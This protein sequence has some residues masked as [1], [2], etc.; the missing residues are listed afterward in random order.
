[1]SVTYSRVIIIILYFLLFYFEGQERF[2]SLTRVYYKD[3]SACV[4]MFDVTSIKSF[5]HV[6]RWKNDVDSKV[7]LRDMSPVPCLL[8]GNKVCLK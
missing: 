8:L 4:I 6:V 7:F 2:S 1:M 5:E 3:A